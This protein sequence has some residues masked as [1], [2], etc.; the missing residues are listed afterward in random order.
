ARVR[1]VDGAL[2]DHRAALQHAR[3]REAA[4]GR[5]EALLAEARGAVLGLEGGADAVLEVEEE[6]AQR[7]GIGSLAHAAPSLSA[8]PSFSPSSPAAGAAPARPSKA[9]ASLPSGPSET[10]VVPPRASGPNS[11]ASAIGSLSSR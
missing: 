3:P 2:L 8:S 10:R 6:R 9:K 4:R 7:R 1:E 11:T 5:L